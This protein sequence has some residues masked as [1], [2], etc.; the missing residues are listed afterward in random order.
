MKEY[1]REFYSSGAW[2]NTREAYA[3][4]R[5]NLCE[6]CLSKGI[7]TPGEIVHHKVHLTPLNINDPTVTLNWDNLQLVCRDCHA[8]I[9]DRKKRRYKIDEYGRVICSPHSS[10]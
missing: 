2:K 5:H 10:F 9:H 7:Y 6:I 4:Y 1:A 8:R 3:K